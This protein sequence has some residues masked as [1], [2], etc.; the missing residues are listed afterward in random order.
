MEDKKGLKKEKEKL[1]SHQ[2]RR[3]FSGRGPEHM[4][5]N[6]CKPLSSKRTVPDGQKVSAANLGKEGK[7]KI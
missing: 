5:K 6:Y 7:K 3:G 2:P 1:H 4:G